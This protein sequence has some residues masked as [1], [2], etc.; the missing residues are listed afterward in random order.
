M[1]RLAALVTVMVCSLSWPLVQAGSVTVPGIGGD[2]S[3]PVESYQEK[4]FHQV[5]RQQYD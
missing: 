5:L 1:G 3:I 4:S 2:L